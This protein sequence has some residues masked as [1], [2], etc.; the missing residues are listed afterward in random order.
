MSEKDLHNFLRLLEK[1]RKNAS[2]HTKEEADAF[3]KTI[4]VLT[5]NGNVAEPFKNICIPKSQA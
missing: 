5:K 2:K 1:E 3:L 4:G